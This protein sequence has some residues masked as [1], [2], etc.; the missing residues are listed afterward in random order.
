VHG[1]SVIAS[2]ACNT[3]TRD[4]YGDRDV[5]LLYVLHMWTLCMVVGKVGMM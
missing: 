2:L 1:P 5:Q 3:R 4:A